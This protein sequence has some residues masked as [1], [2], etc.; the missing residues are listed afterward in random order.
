MPNGSQGQGNIYSTQAAYNAARDAIIEAFENP[1]LAQG[2]ASA[3]GYNFN[4]L[5]PYTIGY[6]LDLFNAGAKAAGYF[7]VANAAL[8]A[9]GQDTI[10][11]TAAM[12]AAIVSHNANAIDEQFDGFSVTQVQAQALLD[13]SA[14]Y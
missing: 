1:Q 3:G 13:A 7:D 2:Q 9:A 11:F 6:G 14:P 10:A 4:N 5:E 12:R 8:A